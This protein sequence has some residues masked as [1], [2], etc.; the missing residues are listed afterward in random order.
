MQF[1]Q[2]TTAGKLL[3]YWGVA[4]ALVMITGAVPFS[5]DPGLEAIGI[6]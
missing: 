3:L 6:R 4:S 5:L 1:K 2:T